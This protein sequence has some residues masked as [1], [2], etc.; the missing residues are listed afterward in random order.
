MA[1]VDFSLECLS[2]RETVLEL[3][4]REPVGA[5]E[6]RARRV[7]GELGDPNRASRFE[8]SFKVSL[9]S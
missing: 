2:L 8:I 5:F 6:L 3:E 9:R 4:A 7:V 1:I